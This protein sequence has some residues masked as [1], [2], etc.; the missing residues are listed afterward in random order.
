M[1]PTV[2]ERQLGVG[3]NDPL[4]GIGHQMCLIAWSVFGA[5]RAIGWHRTTKANVGSHLYGVPQGWD[6]HCVGSECIRLGRISPSDHSW[7]VVHSIHASADRFERSAARGVF[8]CIPVERPVVLKGVVL[9]WE[10]SGD[11]GRP[12]WRAFPHTTSAFYRR[13][14]LYKRPLIQSEIRKRSRNFSR[15]SRQ[16]RYQPM[17]IEHMDDCMLT[18]HMPSATT[19]LEGSERPISRHR[20]AFSRR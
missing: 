11:S 4:T 14:G 8:C 19:P 16:Q 10:P 15:S 18:R 3:G 5:T 7:T 1:C 2:S 13:R 9:N 12:W 6:P 20:P 17:R